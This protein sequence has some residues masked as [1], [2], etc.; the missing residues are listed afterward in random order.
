MA[1]EKELLVKFESEAKIQHVG[2]HTRIP[3]N[4]SLLNFMFVI[5]S[6]QFAPHHL[7][8]TASFSDEI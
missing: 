3:C 4:A 5:S 1:L 2:M 8:M 7:D 6:Q